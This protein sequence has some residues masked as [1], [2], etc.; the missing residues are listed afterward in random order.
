MTTHPRNTARILTKTAT[1]V[2]DRRAGAFRVRDFPE[3]MNG[4]G[5]DAR[6]GNS[7]KKPRFVSY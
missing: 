5:K 6:I 2:R 7:T 1:P 4:G 3:K